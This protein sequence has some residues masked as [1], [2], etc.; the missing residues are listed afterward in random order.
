[1]RRQVVLDEFFNN[2]PERR[3]EKT[4]KQYE[5]ATIK[6]AEPDSD[7]TVSPKAIKLDKGVFSDEINL[8][9]VWFDFSEFLKK[10]GIDGDEYS[11]LLVQKDGF[12]VEEY[13]ITVEKDKTIIT[14]SEKE[15]IRRGVLKLEDMLVQGNGNLE[16]ATTHEKAIIKRRIS[17]GFFAPINRPPKGANELRDDTDYYPEPYLN[18]MMHDGVNALWV[19]S[20]FDSLVESSYI[21]EFGVGREPAIKKLNKLIEKCAKYGMEIFM[22][23]IA[24]MSLFEPAIANKYPGIAEKYPQVHGNSQYGPTAFCVYTEFGAGYLKE[25]SEG[26]IKSAPGLGGIMSITWGERVTSCGNTWGSPIKGWSSNCPHCGDKSKVDSI[27]RTVQLFKEGMAEVDPKYDFISWTYGLRGA[28]NEQIEEYMQKLPDEAIAMVNFEDDGRVNQLGKKRFA[29]DYY[30]CYPGPS[31]MYRAA[32]ALAKKYN[33][34]MYAKM[35][36]CCSH[37]LASVPYIPVP[38]LIYDKMMGA[39]ETGTTGV[40]E[41]WFFGSYPCLMSKT[42]GML[43]GDKEYLNKQDFLF[44]LAKLYWAKKDVPHAVSAWEYFEKAYTA[45]PV[46]VMFNYYGPMH[47]GIVWDLQLKPKNFGLPRTWQLMDKTDGDRIGECLFYGHTIDEAIILCEEICFNWEKGCEQL[48]FTGEWNNPDNEQVNV[49]KA[50]NLLFHSGLNILKFYRHR[51][52][53]GYARAD[54]KESL[55]AMRKIVEDEIKN[56]EKMIPLCVADTRL[57]WHSEAEGYKYHPE[58]L[59]ARIEKLKNLLETEFKEVEERIEKGLIPLTYYYG[60]EE[61]VIRAKAGRNG[62]DSAEWISFSDGEDKG[63]CNFRIAENGDDIELEIL[64]DGK[65]SNDN[66]WVTFETELM[67]PQNTYIF[68]NSGTV[69]L[70]REGPSHQAINDERYDEFK[71]KWKIKNLSK[72]GETHLLGTVSKK[73]IQFVRFPFKLNVHHWSGSRWAHETPGCGTGTLGKNRC[74]PGE[75][76]WID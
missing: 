10:N 32:A 67:Y 39:K 26:L 42:V 60:E 17:R 46:N 75:F 11:V 23:L 7:N 31:R 51:Q 29:F 50:L 24:P 47:D 63:S 65:N 27:T 33:R 20:D 14:A 21:P 68:M 13:E 58:K 5:F 74:T 48:S 41:C 53:I 34:T 43:S 71:N 55:C 4:L 18:R 15:G 6:F 3:F 38:G 64:L 56:S 12:E 16:L 19:Y 44:D 59:K 70:W 8:T 28:S 35:Q 37:E 54:Y 62:I 9:P 40:M 57:G 22:F 66:V 61:D 73:D 69:E 52:N 45:Y 72:N 25:A 1:M 30:L 76:G 49:A 36:I 2:Q